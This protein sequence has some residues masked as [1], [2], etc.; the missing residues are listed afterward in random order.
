MGRRR[1]RRGR[2]SFGKTP[3]PPMLLRHRQNLPQECGGQLPPDD[4]KDRDPQRGRYGN[5]IATAGNTRRSI[6]LW[7]SS[8]GTG[9]YVSGTMNPSGYGLDRKQKCLLKC[10]FH[11]VFNRQSSACFLRRPEA[12]GTRSNDIVPC[13][14]P[15][16]GSI[17]Q[18]TTN[19]VCSKG[20]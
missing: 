10:H 17:L 20:T 4:L 5:A 8:S 13:A 7:V 16:P 9:L 11:P 2:H 3:P 14:S 19:F 12:D 6:T 18:F 1:A 15:W